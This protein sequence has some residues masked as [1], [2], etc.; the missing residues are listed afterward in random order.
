MEI[1]KDQPVF[2]A[3]IPGEGMTAPV[4]GRPWQN[5]PKLTTIDEVATHYISAMSSKDFVEKALNGLE[6]GVPITTIADIM[7][8]QGVMEGIH[9]A[10]LGILVSPILVEYLMYTGDRFD[11]EYVSGLEEVEEDNPD[12]LAKIALALCLER[13]QKNEC[14]LGWLYYWIW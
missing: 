2:D 9:S 11:T 6:T 12:M 7:Q 8:T 14:I 3:P 10:D 13:N 5:P 4:G 1:P